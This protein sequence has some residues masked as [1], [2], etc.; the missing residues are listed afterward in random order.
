MVNRIELDHLIDR[1]VNAKSDWQ[2]AHVDVQLSAHR[3]RVDHAAEVL[4]QLGHG[5]LAGE[6]LRLERNGSRPRLAEEYP[7]AA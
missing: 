3:A 6:L 7:P 4:V 1:A 2:D 5:H